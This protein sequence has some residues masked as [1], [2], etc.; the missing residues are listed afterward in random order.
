MFS[1]LTALAAIFSVPMVA[2]GL[3]RLTAPIHGELAL[4]GLLL[5]AGPYRAVLLPWVAVYCVWELGSTY[6]RNR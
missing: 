3:F 4:L 2:L 6:W 1:T 5:S